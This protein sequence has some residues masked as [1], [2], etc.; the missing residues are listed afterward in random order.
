MSL[1][2]RLFLLMVL[3][4]LFA[5]GSAVVLTLFIGNGITKRSLDLAL[6]QS[7]SVQ[8]RFLQQR[9][10]QLELIARIPS[11][12]PDVVGYLQE[13]IDRD[14]VLSILDLL[15]EY[16]Q[17]L[18]FDFALVLDYDGVVICRTD[19]EDAAGDDLSESELIEIAFDEG[20][21]SG[22][23][24][25]AGSLY[26]AVAVPVQQQFDLIGFMVTGYRIDE[27][28]AR[29]VGQLT[30]ADI[31]YVVSDAPGMG[32]AATTLDP[33]RSVELAQQ[34]RLRGGLNQLLA[35]SGNIEL[36]LGGESWLAL[37][38]PLRDAAQEPVGATVSLASVNRGSAGYRRLL[39]VLVAVGVLSVIAAVG[40]SF[41]LSRRIAKPVGELVSAAESARDGNYEVVLPREGSDE[42]GRLSGALKGLLGELREKRDMEMFVSSLSRSLPDPGLEEAPTE[43]GAARTEGAVLAVEL[44][45]FGDPKAADV[46]EVTVSRME[47][48]LRKARSIIRATHGRLESFQGHRLLASFTEP[49]GATQALLAAAQLT[50]ELGRS[51]SSFEDPEPPA[52]ALAYG[53]LVVGRMSSGEGPRAVVSGLPVQQL[54]SLLREATVGDIIVSKKLRDVVQ[55]TV[56]ETGELLREQRGLIS[57]QPLYLLDRRGAMAIGQRLSMEDIRSTTE[58]AQPSSGST[59]RSAQTM[60]ELTAGS[61]LGDRYEIQQVLGAGGMGIVYKALDRELGDLVALKMLR[62]GFASGADL[63]QLKNELRLARTVTH[64]NVVRTFDLGEVEGHWFISMEYVRGLTLRY[65][66]QQPGRIPY[67]AGLRLVKQL[68]AGLSAAHG[69]QVLHLDIKPENIVVEA[70]GNAKLMDFGISRTQQSFAGS[71]SDDQIMG[72]PHYLAPEQI[73]GQTPDVRT[74]LYATGVVM[75]EVFTGALPFE[76]S[77]PMEILRQHLDVEPTPARQHWSG[78]PEDLDACIHQCLA[79]APDDRFASAEQ[80]GKALDDLTTGS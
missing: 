61:V 31:A 9:L 17:D 7:Q 30:T 3:L 42:V 68:C 58:L 51:E 49:E 34:L 57:T 36:E 13:A 55:S 28:L 64:P 79:K 23:W 54:D 59:A 43:P 46:P 71:R 72:T 39:N 29:E 5:A 26:T 15:R 33:Q 22:I 80:L 78:I 53:A 50:Q 70:N 60:E 32:V 35:D 63:D 45:R 21:A 66:L 73:G 19:R 8:S 18:G 56:E 24:S 16:Q 52:V 12:D 38:A 14:N 40:L 47:R 74:D 65:L 1:R 2:T 76:G 4:V 25:E 75:Y 11:R 37:V 62:T 41:A 27:R 44:R 77:T 69:Q 10:D 20:R 67:S 6:T 48:D